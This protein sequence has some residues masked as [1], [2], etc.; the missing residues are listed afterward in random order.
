MKIKINRREFDISNKD[1]VFDNGACYQ[2][3]TQTYFKDWSNIHPTISKSQFEKLLKD[4]LLV[5]VKE[6]LAWTTSSG[7]EIWYRYYAFDIEK[8]V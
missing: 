7:E 2:L 5:L 4:G 8:T 6:R 3:I 1:I